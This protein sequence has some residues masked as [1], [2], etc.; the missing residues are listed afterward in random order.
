MDKDF[1][2]LIL[3]FM[4]LII[5]G[6]RLLLQNNKYIDDWDRDEKEFMDEWYDIDYNIKRKMN[7]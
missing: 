5:Y 6:M 3:L 2:K 1:I 4:K 7:D